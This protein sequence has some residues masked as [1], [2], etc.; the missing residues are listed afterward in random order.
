MGCKAGVTGTVQAVNRNG[1]VQI[2]KRVPNIIVL[3]LILLLVLDALLNTSTR[4]NSRSIF[5]F[6]I[7][8][9]VGI[10]RIVFFGHRR[11][12]QDGE[13]GNRISKGPLLAYIF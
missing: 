11:F 2:F 12:G 7:G 13:I 6:L 8:L 1:A 3:V 9:T 4:G 10:Q 5:F